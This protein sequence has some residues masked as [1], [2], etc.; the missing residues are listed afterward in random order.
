M[1]ASDQMLIAKWTQKHVQPPYHLIE[2]GSVTITL[3]CLL[4]TWEPGCPDGYICTNRL[5]CAPLIS[6]KLA[7][8]S[9]ATRA[10][11]RLLFMATEKAMPWHII[12]PPCNSTT[13][14]ATP[15]SHSSCLNRLRLHAQ[16]QLHECVRQWQQHKEGQHAVAQ[17]P[18]EPLEIARPGT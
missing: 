16:L 6:T 2:I 12:T 1:Q 15:L 4:R 3:L 18:P 7:A 13:R 10:L 8:I 11:P 17:Q 14:K 9:R 5:L